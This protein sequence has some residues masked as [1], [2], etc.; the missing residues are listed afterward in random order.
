LKVLGVKKIAPNHCTGKRAVKGFK[1]AWGKN[2][3]EAGCGA[4]IEIS[5]PKTF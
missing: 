3:L 4:R 2:F 1:K 5:V